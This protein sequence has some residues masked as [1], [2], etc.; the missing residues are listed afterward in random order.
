MIVDARSCMYSGASLGIWDVTGRPRDLPEA[1]TG[2][3]I[4][5]LHYKLQPPY[6]PASTS[7]SMSFPILLSIIGG[8]TSL[9]PK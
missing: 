9:S 3:G 5:S 7:V 2:A 8:V 4:Q 6:K 1:T